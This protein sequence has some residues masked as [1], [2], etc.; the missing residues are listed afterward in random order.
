M[1]GQSVLSYSAA[2]S[3][4]MHTPSRMTGMTEICRKVWRVFS[5]HLLPTKPECSWLR[6]IVTMIASTEA[7]RSA[8]SGAAPWY[9]EDPCRGDN[10]SMVA[11]F[12]FPVDTPTFLL[13]RLEP[14][15]TRDAWHCWIGL[16][17]FDLRSKL[18]WLM[19]N[20]W[21]HPVIQVALP[22]DSWCLRTR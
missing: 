14:V 7:L 16:E 4:T 11:G 8:C 10:E 1:C 18:R 22:L 21:K 12:W 2:V 19:V 5:V 17:Y 3:N 9:R 6:H 20:Q 13:A 15:R